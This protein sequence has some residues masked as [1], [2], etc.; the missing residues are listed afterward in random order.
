M[1]L[2]NENDDGRTGWGIARGCKRK[3]SSRVWVW[4][5][6]SYLLPIFAD[7]LLEQKHGQVT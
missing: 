2:K 6:N 7:G 4:M 1:L 3:G 5:F